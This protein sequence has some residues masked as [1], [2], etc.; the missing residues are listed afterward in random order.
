MNDKRVNPGVSEAVSTPGGLSASPPLAATA[1]PLVLFPWS[2]KLETGI[3]TID[4][5]HRKLVDLLNRLANTLIGSEQAAIDEAIEKLKDYAAR[6]FEDEEAIWDSHFKDDTWIQSHKVAHDSFLPTLAEFTN[7]EG[8]TSHRELS[9]KMVKFLVRWLAFHIIDSDKRMAIAVEE[10]RQG[11]GVEGAKNVANEKMAGSMRVLTETVLAMYEAL[12]SR[13]LELMRER[14]ARNEAE[15]KLRR[16]FE[17]PLDMLVVVDEEGTFVQVNPE[18]SRLLGYEKDLIHHHRFVEFVH[19][20]DVESSLAVFVDMLRSGSSIVD[21]SNRYRCHDGS[22]RWL[23]WKAARAGDPPLVYASARDITALVEQQTV[24]EKINNELKERYRE[25]DE[26][27][28]VASH[29]LQEPLRKL[30]SFCGLLKNDLG[31]DI[32]PQAQKDVEFISQAASRMQR[33]ISDLL[34]LSRMGR[35]ALKRELVSLDAC[36]DRAIDALSAAFLEV[37]ALIE[38]ESL[39]EVRGDK[40]MLTQLYQNLLG[41]AVKF[42][43]RDRRPQIRLTAERSEEGTIFGVRDNGIGIEEQYVEQIFVPFRRLHGRSAYPGSGIGLAICR[44]AVERHGGRIWVESELGKGSHFRFL[45]PEA[46][47]ER[48]GAAAT[49]SAEE[50][51]LS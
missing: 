42:A 17:L 48:S 27:S 14:H 40:V 7:T 31:E 33:L 18:F 43:A 51:T 39:P 8:W 11:M 23:S 38:R 5:Q 41:N 25:L 3:E 49:R 35:S 22:Y 13:A 12:S 37:D 20:D 45:L 2:E 28:Y 30:V 19:P 24:I 16:F 29:D 15:S 34:E 9:E 44:K 21:F 10:M 46:S 6:H 32:P 1:A 36:V 50:G 47:D 4:Q 26:F